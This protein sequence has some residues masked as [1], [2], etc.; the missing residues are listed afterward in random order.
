MNPRGQV[1][2]FNSLRGQAVDAPPSP[3]V[4][5]D[6]VKDLNSPCGKGNYFYKRD[7]F[8]SVFFS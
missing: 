3:E 8:L 5:F 6:L 1:Q 4:C 7:M 2:D